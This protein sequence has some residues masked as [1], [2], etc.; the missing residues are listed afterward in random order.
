MPPIDKSAKR[1]AAFDSGAFLKWLVFSALALLFL[2]GVIVLIEERSAREPADPRAEMLREMGLD[3]DAPVGGPPPPPESPVGTQLR[4]LDAS[5][6]IE[7]IAGIQGAM[8]LDPHAA[9]GTVMARL[10]D[11]V[12]SVRA[13]AATALMTAR[14]PNLGAAM[15]RL[16][17]DPDAAVRQ[18]AVLALTTAY[19]AEPG[20]SRQLEQPLRSRDA[21]AVLAALEVWKRLAPREREDSLRV[22]EPLLYS[23]DEPLLVAA[24]EALQFV[25][26]RHHVRYKSRFESIVAR[27]GDAPPGRAA[28]AMLERL[29]GEPVR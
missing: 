16:L 9:A 4:R 29:A 28:R 23:E 11:P 24:L 22:I 7:R 27:R 19:L 15:I 14:I 20:L 21:G 10:A 3:P 18:T 13:A 17:S 5:D 25:D 2:V 26:S 1:K 8:A 6:P 12:P